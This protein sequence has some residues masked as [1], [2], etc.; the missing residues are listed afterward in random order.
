MKVCNVNCTIFLI[1]GIILGIFILLSPETFLSSRIY[2]SYMSIIPFPAIVA[3]GATFVIISGEIDLSF[4]S[5]MALSGFVFSLVFSIGGHPLLG[6]LAALVV[7]ILIGLINGLIVVKIG[8]PSII[9]TIGTQFFWSGFTMVISS[10]LAINIVAIRDTLTHTVFVGR[11]FWGVPAQALW[12][13]GLVAVLWLILNRHVFG[14]N[15]MFTGD[16]VQTARAMGINVGKT[17]IG[18]FMLLGALTALSGSMVCMEMA[19]W[20]PTQGEG[21]LLPVFAAIFVGGTSVFGGT[22][23]IV[24]T[25]IGAVII[26]MLEAGIVSAGFSGFWTRMAYGVI[27]VGSVSVYAW[28]D[29]SRAKLQP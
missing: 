14:A 3:L 5:T 9:A 19:N 17:K 21:Y 25:L 2:L 13:L 16:N 4:P 6:L 22:G 11:L 1:L 23:T 20:W 27:V 18:A 24:G 15:V 8:V 28:M 7:G 10:G 29:R 12:C 26:G